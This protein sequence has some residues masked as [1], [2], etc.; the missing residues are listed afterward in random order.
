ME[1]N[2]LHRLAV[3]GIIKDDGNMYIN[4]RFFK[5][6]YIMTSEEIT[7]LL[8]NALAMSMKLTSKDREL[9]N[10]EQAD[11][12]RRIVTHLGTE[13]FDNEAFKDLEIYNLNK[14]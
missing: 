7:T 13:F 8:T 1:E 14:T 5:E 12:V 3:E 2:K 10:Q 4:F 11:F 6:D 9:D